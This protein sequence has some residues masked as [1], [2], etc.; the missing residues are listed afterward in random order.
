MFV[1]A[2]AVVAVSSIADANFIINTVAAT[3]D[4]TDKQTGAVTLSSASAASLGLLGGAAQLKGLLLEAVAPGRG[5]RSAQYNR[6]ITIADLREAAKILNYFKE[7]SEQYKAR[8]ANK[9]KNKNYITQLN[10]TRT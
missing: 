9:A 1:A 5:K 3:T 7:G 2:L 6:E 8:T 10:S 4:Q